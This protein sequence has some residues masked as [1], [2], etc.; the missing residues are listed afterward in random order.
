MMPVVRADFVQDNPTMRLLAKLM[1]NTLWG[2]LAIQDNKSKFDYVRQQKRFNRLFY[3]N[4]YDIHY[5]NVLDDE[6]LQLQSVMLD[7]AGASDLRS[8][9]VI[10]AFVTSYARLELQQAMEFVGTE[11]L[12]YVDTDCV[13]EIEGPSY[14]TLSIGDCLGDI[15][16]ETGE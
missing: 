9:V 13:S 4:Q 7:A 14:P 1:L 11:Q 6:T 10:A 3:S 12:I 8:N 2:R 5:V 16:S 15:K